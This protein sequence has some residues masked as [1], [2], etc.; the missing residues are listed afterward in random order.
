MRRMWIPAVLAAAAAL[1]G[2]QQHRGQALAA[3]GSQ[4]AIGNPVGPVPGPD[5]AM[6]LPENP[7]AHDKVALAEGKKLFARFN[8]SG[9]HGDHAGGGMGPSLRDEAWMYGGSGADI[10]S[11]I[12]EGRAHGMPAWGTKLTQD[13]IWKLAAYIQSMRTPEEPEPP[14]P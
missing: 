12:A 2:C 11:T 6:P 8:C 14:T 9:C 3:E 1:F 10:F 7:Y 13:Q 4:P 5:V